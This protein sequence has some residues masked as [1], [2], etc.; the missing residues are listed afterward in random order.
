VKVS[1]G[2]QINRMRFVPLIIFLSRFLHERIR[3]VR[4]GDKVVVG[5][6]FIEFEIDDQL[7]PFYKSFSIGSF[8]GF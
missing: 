4:H 3:I 1:S 6:F 7:A 5:C 8:S 2:I